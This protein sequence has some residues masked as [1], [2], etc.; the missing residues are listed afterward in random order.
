MSKPS[1]III[2]CGSIGERHLRAFLKNDQCRVIAAETNA[3]LRKHI[4]EVHGVET[5][6]DFRPG[7]ERTEVIGALVATPAP[8]HV[9][10]AREI[11]DSGRHVLIEKPLSL[12]LGGLDDLLSLRDTRKVVA[13]IAY[14]YHF[15]PAITAARDFIREESFGPVLQATISGGQHF[16]TYRPA[17]REIYYA[18]REMGGGAIQDALTHLANATDWILGPA[19]NLM[20]DAG[21]QCLEGVEVEDTVNVIT[22]QGSA[23][24]SYQLNQFQSPN[25]IVFSFH[26]ADGTVRI[27]LHHQRWG[28]FAHGAEAWT[29]HDTPVRDR[30]FV[31]E[32]QAEAFVAAMAGESTPLATLEA[33]IRAVAFNRAAFQSI[34][35]GRRISTSRDPSGCCE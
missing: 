9:A 32:K 8:S 25:E 11:M 31:F 4:A 14:V 22:R 17:Y 24:V 13:A 29:W 12:D 19:D 18:R 10:I 2:G 16:P 35:E 30:D 1:I 26:C 21:H 34:K 27:E 7:L 28:T 6:A 15:I 20:A 5:L 3:A 33:G 23:L